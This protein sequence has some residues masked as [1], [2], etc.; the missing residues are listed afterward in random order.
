MQVD[1]DLKPI[2]QLTARI[3][4]QPV[5]R[6]LLQIVESPHV[7]QNMLQKE[8]SLLSPRV[9]RKQILQE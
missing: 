8:A 1:G 6:T 7:V 4:S 2:K 3:I 9:E 5:N